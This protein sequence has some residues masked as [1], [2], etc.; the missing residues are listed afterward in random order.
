MLDVEAFKTGAL[1]FL[2]AFGAAGLFTI[3]FKYLYQWT[4][5]Y[6]EPKLIGA[7]NVAASVALG[8][9]LIGYALPLASALSQAAGLAEFAAWAALA[10]IIQIVTFLVVRRLAVPDVGARIERGELSIAVYLAAISI[11]VGLL[12]AASMTE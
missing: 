4:T 10:A 3:A 8:G 2:V 7:G 11:V 12:N 6:D 9:A 1:H 5:P